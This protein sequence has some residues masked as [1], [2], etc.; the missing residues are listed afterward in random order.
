MT[1]N[2]SDQPKTAD[3]IQ[4]WLITYMVE[5]L[6][7]DIDKNR[8][9]KQTHFNDFGLDSSSAVILTGDLGEWLG[10]DLDPTL[11]LDHPTLESLINHLSE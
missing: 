10:Y 8:I 1:T 7:I 6:N 2:F 3:E 11:L 4:N 9:D 5:E